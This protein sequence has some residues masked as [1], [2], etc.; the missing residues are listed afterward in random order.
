VHG[1]LIAAS[2]EFHD[3]WQSE[4]E[5]KVASLASATIL[6]NGEETSDPNVLACPRPDDFDI[7]SSPP[8][9]AENVASS[10]TPGPAHE[11]A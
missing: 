9:V 11:C 8:P 10:F 4:G 7:F 5:R 1:L 6:E 3:Q 2:A